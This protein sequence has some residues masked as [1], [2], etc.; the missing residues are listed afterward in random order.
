MAT[1]LALGRW[2]LGARARRLLDY[3]QQCQA[4]SG[5]S[6]GCCTSCELMEYIQIFL[7]K[8][9]YSKKNVFTKGRTNSNEDLQIAL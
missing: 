9:I 7:A 1:I 5:G 2:Y 6:S 4:N 3:H 8:K